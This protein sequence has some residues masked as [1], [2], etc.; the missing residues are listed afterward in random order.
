MKTMRFVKRFRSGRVGRLLIAADNDRFPTADFHWRGSRPPFWE[1]IDW[2]KC[3]FQRWSTRFDR[4]AQFVA[5]S[6]EGA[7]EFWTFAPRQPP[8]YIREEK[9]PPINAAL[10]SARA[11]LSETRRG[12]IHGAP[13]DKCKHLT[14]REP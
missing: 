8:R 14:G 7:C 5:I 1:I 4:R 9:D 2:T 6:R 10:R 12:S 13:Q 3:C 11:M